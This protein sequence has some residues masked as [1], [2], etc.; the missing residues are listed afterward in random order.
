S[1]STD[2][3]CNDVSWPF[4]WNGASVQAIADRYN[5]ARA[6]DP[7]VTVDLTIPFSQAEWDALTENEKGL[8]LLNEERVDRG[9]F[10]V[11]AV[12]AELVTVAQDHADYHTDYYTANG[13]VSLQHQPTVADWTASGRDASLDANSNGSVS[14]W[15]RMNGQQRLDENTEF[16]SFGEK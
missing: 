14:P 4:P 2:D 3:P 1:P 9:I 6:S 12:V 11:S 15:E 7:T 10:P 13:S 5:T 16:F 8:F